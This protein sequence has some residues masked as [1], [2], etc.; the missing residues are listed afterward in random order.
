[1]NCKERQTSSCWQTQ[2]SVTETLQI[3]SLWLA[4]P[5]TVG[6][7]STTKSL[8]KSSTKLLPN[9]SYKESK[10]TCSANG[11]SE[12]SFNTAVENADDKAKQ[13]YPGTVTGMK[14]TACKESQG[15]T[16]ETKPG[17]IAKHTQPISSLLF[18]CGLPKFHSASER[19]SSW[20]ES[21]HG[22]FSVLRADHQ[23]E[24]AM[25]YWQGF[26]SHN[27]SHMLYMLTLLETITGE[28]K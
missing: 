12:E 22:K 27:V 21:S 18:G 14:P 15:L 20:L 6:L 25:K 4:Y 19:Q 1:M 17:N 3:L 26:I 23:N 16:L 5:S 11:L 24:M 10:K 7:R 2:F 9:S 28:V 8:G 13:K